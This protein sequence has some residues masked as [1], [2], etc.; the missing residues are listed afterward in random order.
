VVKSARFEWDDAKAA[1]T[2]RERGLAFDDAATVT[3]DARHI[4]AVDKRRNYG[5]TRVKVIGQSQDGL[6]M[7]LIVTRRGGRIRII[8]AR[9][10]SR[11]ERMIYDQAR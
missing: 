4:E 8:S 9:L 1:W 11:K 6:M 5:E 3:D 7:T 10:A 2:L